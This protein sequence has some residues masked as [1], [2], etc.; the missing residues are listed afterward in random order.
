MKRFN[1]F[2]HKKVDDT[3][4]TFEGRF[5]TDEEIEEMIQPKTGTFIKREFE[6]IDDMLKSI[7]KY[8]D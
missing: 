3:S 4:R 2:R 6:E 8:F 1:I 7:E 5:I